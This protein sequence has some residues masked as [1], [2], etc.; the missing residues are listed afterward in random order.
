MFEIEILYVE[1][2]LGADRVLGMTEILW[3]RGQQE[4]GH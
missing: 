3:L 1:E 2:V 4:N